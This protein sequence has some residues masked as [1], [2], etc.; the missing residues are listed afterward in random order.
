[1]RSFLPWSC[2]LLSLI[3][4]VCGDEGSSADDDHDH[5]AEPDAAPDP[6]PDAAPPDAGADDGCDEAAQLPTQW[7]PID[8]VST[9]AVVATTADGV[10]TATIDAT[11]GGTAN[12]ADNPYIY[13]DLSAGAKVELGDV[14]ALDDARWHVAFKR[15]SLRV[16]G[17]DSGTGG[18]TAAVVA[19]GSLAEVTAA[20][21]AGYGDDQFVDE[22]C[23][24]V[25]LPGGEPA[26]V[27]GEWYDYDPATHS[28][29][30][31]AEVYVIRV[32]GEGDFKLR[33]VTYYGDDAN[34]MRGAIYRVEWAAL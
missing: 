17:G 24:F 11:A 27:L 16:N 33:V 1:M 15:A 18:V 10:T 23:A 12:A 28:L 8:L 21:G 31:Q 3:V 29:S 7:R 6:D 25:G 14:D 22:A 26:T 32:P 19:A 30:P 5:D 4:A 20:P 34:P 9:G 13:V 2:L